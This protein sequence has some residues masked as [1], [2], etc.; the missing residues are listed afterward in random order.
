ME[1]LIASTEAADMVC[2][3]E[4]IARMTYGAVAGNWRDT[5]LP[6]R[7]SPSTGRR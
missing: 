5:V 4:R 7:R 6:E 1:E 2:T 3:R